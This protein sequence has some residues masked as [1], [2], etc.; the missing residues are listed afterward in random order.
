LPPRGWLTSLFGPA[1][2]TTADRQALLRGARVDVADPGPTVCACFG[3]GARAIESAVRGGCA[4]V[5]AIGQRLKAGTN[6][7]SCRP[8]LARIIGAVPVSVATPG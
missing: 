8:E 5:A 4:T 3:V 2:L 7:G 1:P 6:C